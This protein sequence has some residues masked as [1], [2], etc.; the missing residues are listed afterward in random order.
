MAENKKWP[1]FLAQ[2][3]EKDKEHVTLMMAAG[4]FD[5]GP[6]FP[7]AVRRAQSIELVSNR[8]AQ[9]RRVHMLTTFEPQ[10]NEVDDLHPI[11]RRLQNSTHTL[12]LA[13]IVAFLATVGQCRDPMFRRSIM[14]K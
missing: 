11:E 6:Q 12:Y 2:S 7:H 10:G 3:P 1:V 5:L 13:R 8:P 9:S 4:E 14:I